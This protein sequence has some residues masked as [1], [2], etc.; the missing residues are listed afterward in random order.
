MK[1]NNSNQSQLKPGLLAL[2]CLAATLASA[3]AVT[4]T[5]AAV[6]DAAVGAAVT[7]LSNLALASDGA[8]AFSSSDLGANFDAADVNDGLSDNS[9]YSWIA[10]TT[11]TNEFVG[12]QFPSP[13][14]IGEV[15]W[16]GEAGYNGPFRGPVEPAIHD[17][18][19]PPAPTRSGRKSAPT[20]TAKRAVR[21]RC[22][23][24]SLRF[25]R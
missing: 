10:S 11:A 2:A 1:T 19:P 15:D 23:A 7:G 5:P 17:G 12:V 24:R 18:F 20:S 22:R 21:R 4:L 6:G 16:L 9:G 3:A 13:V 8:T 25:R 14:T